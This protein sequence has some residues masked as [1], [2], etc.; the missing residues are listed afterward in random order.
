MRACIRARGSV[1][2]RASMWPCLSSMQRVW[3]IL[4]RHLWPNTLANIFRHYLI[5]GAI[6]EKMVLNIK[7]V[8]WFSLQLLSK[9]FLIPRRIQRDSH[10]CENIFMLSNRYSC[11]I[12]MKLQFSRQTFG[13]SSNIKFHQNPSSGSQIVPCGRTDGH[14]ANSR[15]SQICKSAWNDNQQILLSTASAQSSK[16]TKMLTIQYVAR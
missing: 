1:H 6:F 7:C 9:P 4:W 8:F 12:L 10:K 16:A 3:A 14:E 11:R 15:F 13:K 2:A 5:N